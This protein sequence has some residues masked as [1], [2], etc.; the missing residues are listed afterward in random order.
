[1]ATAEI[2]SSIYEENMICDECDSKQGPIYVY[3]HGLRAEVRCEECLPHCECG[4]LAL[5]D[6]HDYCYACNEKI[7]AEEEGAE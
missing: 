3:R 5:S 4:D 7:V 2:Y 6:E 1:M